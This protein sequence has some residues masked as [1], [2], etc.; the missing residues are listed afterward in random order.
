MMTIHLPESKAK[1]EGL[2][3]WIIRSG[4]LLCSLLLASTSLL[5]NNLLIRASKTFVAS[6]SSSSSSTSIHRDSQ[7]MVS[8]EWLTFDQLSERGTNTTWNRATGMAD[9]DKR[10][11]MARPPFP[12]ESEWLL[13]PSVYH[14]SHQDGQLIPK[15]L[16]KV[17]LSTKGDFTKFTYDMMTNETI[18]NLTNPLNLDGINRLA[19]AHRSWKVFNP[20][21]EI[22]YFNLHHCRTYLARNFHPLMLRAFDCIEAFA[23]KAD[24][25]RYL[26]VYREG[27]FYSDW[28]QE[29]MVD[30]LLDRVAAT[31]VT[32]VAATDSGL[33]R[34]WKSMQNSFIGATPRHPVLIKTIEILLRNIQS[35][36]DLNQSLTTHNSAYEMTS[37]IP[38][39]RAFEAISPPLDKPGGARLID[40]KANYGLRF[41]WGE[42]IVIVHKCYGCGGDQNWADGNNY[43]HKYEIGEFFCPDAPSLFQD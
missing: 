4:V 17:L 23:G 8:P 26:V 38:L 29:C 31:N 3:C 9:G 21:Y 14:N 33:P 35:R 6:S 2:R 7:R 37:T 20:G 10:G 16:H 5:S 42:D 25:F 11:L 15:L 41:F 12:N 32:F 18:Q 39:G 34:G 28:K 43:L 13:S 24:L 36:S 19:W 22:R 40:F 27:G 30:G 1:Q